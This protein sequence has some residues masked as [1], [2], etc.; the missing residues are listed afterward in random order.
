MGKDERTIAEILLDA[1]TNGRTDVIVS[2]IN[3]DSAA[4]QRM[5]QRLKN[6]KATDDQWRYYQR[7]TP[8]RE[9][10]VVV[11]SPACKDPAPPTRQA[12]AAARERRKQN[13]TKPEQN[14]LAEW[15][16]KNIC[17]PAMLHISVVPAKD[18]KR[19]HGVSNYE[20]YMTE[21][22]RQRMNRQDIRVMVREVTKDQTSKRKAYNA[23]IIFGKGNM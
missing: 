6:H 10:V 12:D 11:M 19:L 23:R 9:T 5:I 22:A 21:K 18:I 20:T 13:E 1:L 14:G 2:D 16:L 7:S 15:V 3:S 17:N 4:A 8:D